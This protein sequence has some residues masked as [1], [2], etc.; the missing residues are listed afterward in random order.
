MFCRWQEQQIHY[1]VPARDTDPVLL[2]I[3]SYIICLS[4]PNYQ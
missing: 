2:S 3:A 4:M 1:T